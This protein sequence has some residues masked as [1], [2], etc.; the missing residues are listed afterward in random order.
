MNVT[1]E[2]G[3][4]LLALRY[5][6]VNKTKD[7][8]IKADKWD[9]LIQATQN[10]KQLVEGKLANDN[11]ILDIPKL[12]EQKTKEIPAGN[13]LEGVSL[14]ELKD[15]SDVLLIPNKETFKT[16][17]DVPIAVLSASEKAGEE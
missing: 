13:S 3:Q 11:S 1:G 2:T 10:G 12:I 4:K 9:S 7:Q 15:D 17:D 16:A 6:V 5:T 14:Y 8:A